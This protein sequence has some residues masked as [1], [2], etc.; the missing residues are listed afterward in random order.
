MPIDRISTT[1]CVLLQKIAEKGGASEHMRACRISWISFSPNMPLKKVYPTLNETATFFACVCSLLS[2]CMSPQSSANAPA[3]C[4]ED[5]PLDPSASQGC[6]RTEYASHPTFY[7]KTRHLFNSYRF[8]NSIF[9][10]GTMHRIFLAKFRGCHAV[11]EAESG[12][13]PLSWILQNVSCS[14]AQILRSSLPQP[15]RCIEHLTFSQSIDWRAVRTMWLCLCT[16][17]P[18]RQEL[19]PRLNLHVASTKSCCAVN[20]QCLSAPQP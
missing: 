8:L 18:S 17:L 11:R 15:D 13:G 9:T 1:Y 10:H 14:Q 4:C 20:L 5:S 16:G 12:H 7:S 19:F 3:A 2:L 6:P